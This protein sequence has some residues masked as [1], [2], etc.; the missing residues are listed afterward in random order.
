MSA[1][2]PGLLA[3]VVVLVAVAAALTTIEAA[4]AGFSRARAVELAQEQRSG[5]VSLLRVLDDTALLPGLLDG[6]EAY[7]PRL[8]VVRVP[9]ATH[10]IVHEQPARVAREIGDFLHRAARPAPAQ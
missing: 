6:L 3:L 4:L 8:E 10:W 9:G 7:V 2:S 1:D 5:A